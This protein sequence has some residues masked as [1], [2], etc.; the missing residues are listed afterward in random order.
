MG[1]FVLRGPLWLRRLNAAVWTPSFCCLHSPP[2]V[3]AFDRPLYWCSPV[4]I[5]CRLLAGHDMMVGKKMKMLLTRFCIEPWPAAKFLW[6]DLSLP[7]PS[8]MESLHVVQAQH[9]IDLLHF[10]RRCFCWFH[11]FNDL[12]FTFTRF[13]SSLGISSEIP[14]DIRI[15]HALLHLFF[16]LSVALSEITITGSCVLE[17]LEAGVNSFQ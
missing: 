3:W 14:S 11:S 6:M 4:P 15:I 2:A 12:F 16:Y 1:G 8:Y 9:L 17:G 10:L 13:W 5:I 7:S